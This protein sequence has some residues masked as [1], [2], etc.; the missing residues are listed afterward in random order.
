MF[1]GNYSYG[2]IARMLFNPASLANLSWTILGESLSN[3]FRKR[4]AYRNKLYVGGRKVL[5]LGSGFGGTYALRHLVRSLNKNENVETTM[6]SDENFFLFTPLLHEVATGRIETRH[7]AYPIRKLHW[8][9]RFNFIQG[10]VSKIDLNQHKVTTT[11]ATLDFDYLVL[12]LGS[13]ADMTKLDSTGKKGGSVFTLKTLYDS[14]LLRNHIIGIFERA[15][16]EGDRQWQRQLLTFVVSGG[17]YTGLQI[18][19]E[20]RDFIHGSLIRYYRQINPDDVRIIL[21]EEEPKIVAGLHTKLGAYAMQQLKR[22]GIEVRLGS[23]VTRVW[24]DHLEIN[25]KEIVPTGTLIW[26][27]GTVANPRIAE[28]E[29]DKDSL[30]RVLVNEYLE[31]HGFP[32]VYAVGDCAHFKD[33]K[34]GNPIPPRAHTGVRQAKI[35]AHNILADIRGRSKKPY[36]YSHPAE[37]VSLGSTKA[38]FRFHSFRLYGFPARLIWL[39]AYSFLITGIHNRVRIIMDWLLS[40]IFGRDTPFIEPEK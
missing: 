4:G 9:D 24:D 30:G 10:V 22:M 38:M 35:A 19:T 14:R 33:Q 34:S 17:G 21:I 1:T 5:I 13:I 18:V 11:V 40:L 3:L 37:M 32:G 26:A 25:R 29:V 20:L 8:R 31:V 28:L 27:V 23:R 15:N 36:R 12:A 16:I 2:S 6:V 7:I 39:V